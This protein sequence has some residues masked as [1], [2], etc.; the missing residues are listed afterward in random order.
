MKDK[1]YFNNLNGLRFIAALLVIISHLELNK[2][3]FNEPNYFQNIKELGRLGVSLFF[4]LSG[5][6]I[7]YLLVK[8]KEK[9]GF[10]AIKNFYLRRIYRIWPLYYVIVL[11]SLFVL[12]H[13]IAFNIPHLKLNIESSFRLVLVVFLFVFFLTNVLVNIKLIPFATQTWSIGTEEQFYLIWP[14]IIDKFNKLKPLFIGILLVY[15]LLLF[16][17]ELGVV[18]EFKYFDLFKNFIHLFQLDSLTIGALGALLLN[19]K[20]IL[21]RKITSIPIFI[22][23]LV[24]IIL[25]VVF[26]LYFGFLASSSFA[27]L[28]IVVI[29]NL[30]NHPKL[31]ALLEN[32]TFNFLGKISYGLYM[33]HQIVIVF[34]LNFLLKYNIYNSFFLYVLSIGLTVLVAKI[35]YRFL[36]Q[37]FLIKKEKLATFNNQ[38]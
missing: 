16:V 25:S 9:N 3:Y 13:F 27:L 23:V 12:P 33:Y 10:I 4:V 38:K 5:F 29:L 34:V 24:I 36:E 18:P 11:L 28:F 30:V 26:H 2:S 35:S 19:C 37:P 22:L 31:I 7:T 15:N 20:S 6:L 1:L 8:E 17:F 32:K 21:V 14:L